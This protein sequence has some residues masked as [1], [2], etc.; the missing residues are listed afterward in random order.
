MRIVFANHDLRTE[1]CGQFIDITDDVLEVL[2]RSGIRDGL[3]VV[4]SPHTTCAVLINERERGFMADLEDLLERLAPRG[5]SYRHD[6]PTQRTENLEDPH[7]HP[8]G[9]AHCRQALMASS[10]ESIPV[11]DGR[12]QLGR[13]QRIFLLELDRARE[14][15][16]FI[17]VMGE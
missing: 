15:R 5:G 13:W 3:A 17:Q 4:Y 10:S 14:R 11:V 2:Q 7:E 12:L 9:H 16:V 1:R 8:N 6:D